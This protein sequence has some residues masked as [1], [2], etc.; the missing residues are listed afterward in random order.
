M[1]HMRE[2]LDDPYEYEILIDRESKFHALFKNEVD[3]KYLFIADHDMIYD[4]DLELGEGWIILFG[5]GESPDWLNTTIVNGG[6]QFRIFATVF[7][8]LFKFLQDRNPNIF[9]FSAK[10]KSRQ[11]LYKTFAKKI[12]TYGYNAETKFIDNTL[13]FIFTRN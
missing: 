9:V 12:M 11:R 4:D 1:K 3:T 5:I 7:K 13:Y 8:I 2:L 6:Y 10:E